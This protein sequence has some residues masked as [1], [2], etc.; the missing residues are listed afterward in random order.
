MQ[1]QPN[2]LLVSGWRALAQSYAIVNQ[3]QCVELLRRP[4][5]ELYFQDLPFC[6]PNWGSVRGIFSP[7]DE[8]AIAGIPPLPTGLIADVEL[9]IGFPIDLAARP[10][11]RRTFVFGTA[12]YCAVPTE[13][14]AGGESLERAHRM[15]DSTV[16][17]TPSKWSRAGFIRSGADGDRVRVVPHGVDPAIYHPPTSAQRA[18]ARE[19]H[20]IE[21]DEFVFLHVG[22]MSW[23]KN[24]GA[25]LQAFASVLT[26]YPRAKLYL[27]GM[28]TLY[29]SRRMALA[30]GD[31]L[32][33]HDREAILSRVE[34]IGRPFSFG[35]M[36]SLYHAA[37]C[38]VSPYKAEAFNIPVLEAAA[39][40]LAVIC[41]DGGST[42]DFTTDD[43][44][45]RIESTKVEGYSDGV[46]TTSLQPNPDHLEELM[47]AIVLDDAFRHQAFQQGPEYVQRGFTWKHVVDNLLA[48]LFPG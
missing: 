8:D 27:K 45:W 41:T 44:V 22:A 11:A 15:N 48:T 6:D 5:V 19:K 24:V 42:D 34:Y 4:S 14:V 10:I 28:D 43:F 7:V 46:R 26:R 23:N 40:G 30:A 32:A 17:I 9:R 38:Y 1:T 37:D 33:E 25:I 16:I 13:N 36:A 39:C 2:R 21:D 31:V 18:A 29:P 47:H 35:E 20:R 3:F 12:E